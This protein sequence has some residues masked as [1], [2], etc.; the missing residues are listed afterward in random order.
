M[1]NQLLA[2]PSVSRYGLERFSLADLACR[3]TSSGV[4]VMTLQGRQGQKR[5]SDLAFVWQTPFI[6]PMFII[7]LVCRAI[8]L[9]RC[10]SS[11]RRSALVGWKCSTP[12]LQ[13]ILA[14]A[15]WPPC[16]QPTVLACTA[17]ITDD[18]KPEWSQAQ[19]HENQT[20]VVAVFATS[21][22]WSG[23]TG[24][25]DSVFASWCWQCTA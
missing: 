22:P 7:G 18:V 1:V 16:Q 15:L 25:G 24:F 19:N 10:F 2:L 9:D 3:P 21:S 12:S 11:P 23:S 14:S 4:A 13:V 20:M 17:A 8:F 5:S 6:A